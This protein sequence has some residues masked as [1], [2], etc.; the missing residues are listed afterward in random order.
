MLV[1]TQTESPRFGYPP[2]LEKK[3][4]FSN[5]EKIPFKIFV[6]GDLITGTITPIGELLADGTPSVFK[7]K[8]D[9]SRTL[10]ISNENGVWMMSADEDLVLELGVWIEVYYQKY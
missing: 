9:G 3:F 6:R 10:T 7:V 4:P 2:L 1:S 5:L 8:L